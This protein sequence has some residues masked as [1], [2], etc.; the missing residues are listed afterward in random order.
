MP[1]TKT[2]KRYKHIR[3][4]SQLRCCIGMTG[5]VPPIYIL[6]VLTALFKPC[7]SPAY[8]LPTPTTPESNIAA[9]VTSAN[10]PAHFRF[11]IENIYTNLQIIIHV[12]LLVGT[13]CEPMHHLTTKTTNSP[14][15]IG[16]FLRAALQ[17]KNN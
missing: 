14:Q 5:I 16:R 10:A 6:A 17:L 9:A 7:G 13:R 15:R 2:I 1:A 3:V 12:H 8:A 4:S 11:V